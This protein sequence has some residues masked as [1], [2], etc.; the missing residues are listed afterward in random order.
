MKTRIPIV[1]T[2]CAAS[3]H[4]ATT[5]FC[6]NGAGSDVTVVA[7]SDAN[8]GTSAASP[9]RSVAALSSAINGAALGD[10]ILLCKG[11]AWD[12]FQMR[13]NSSNTPYQTSKV[14]IATYSS[15]NFSTTASRARLSPTNDRA[16]EFNHGSTSVRWGGYVIRD[17]EIYGGDAVGTGTIQFNASIDDVTIENVKASH[18]YYGFGC[19][20]EYGP[21]TGWAMPRGITLRNSDISYIN[22]MGFGGFSCENVLIENN[23]FDHV[24]D[25]TG[26]DVTNCFRLHPLYVS[27]NTVDAAGADGPVRGN[28]IRGNTITNSCLGS[29]QFPTQC[30]CTLIT[31]HSRIQDWTVENNTLLQGPGTA[32]GYCYGIGIAPGNGLA[33]EYQK[34]FTIRRNRLVNMGNNAIWAPATQNGLIENNVIVFEGTS[35]EANGIMID[36]PAFPNINAYRNQRVKIRNNSI[37]VNSALYADAIT[38]N[39]AGSLHEVTGNLIVFASAGSQNHCFGAPLTPSAY[40]GWDRNLCFAASGT[41]AW[42]PTHAT[43]EAFNSATGFDGASLTANPLLVAAPSSANGYS[44]SIQSASPAHNAS[45]TTSSPER[46]FAACAR[47]D[48]SPDIGAFEYFAAPC[49]TKAASSGSQLR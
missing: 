2:L 21:S 28:V 11:G 18:T 8:V 6:D 49:G 14:T 48:G 10:N 24:S 31:G 9:K 23:T 15:P 46:D 4:A 45:S 16:F 37:Y 19:S 33:E 1:L 27:G 42:T 38:L 41:L 5:Y 22:Q 25:C 13:V 30:A 7:G 12:G 39:D 29:N 17:I 36:A 35:N 47:S 32:S 43:R 44:M 3:A 34:N 40:S 20:N 26:L